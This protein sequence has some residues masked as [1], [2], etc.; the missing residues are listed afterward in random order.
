MNASHF[1][2][3]FEDLEEEW[4]ER[5]AE[6]FSEDQIRALSEMIKE[7]MITCMNSM[8]MD[9]YEEDEDLDEVD[10]DDEEDGEEEDE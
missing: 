3:M 4:M 1:E 6:I 8:P 10:E 7:S 5:Y 2:D 9:G